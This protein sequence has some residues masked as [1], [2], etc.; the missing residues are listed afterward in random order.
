MPVDYNYSTYFVPPQKGLPLTGI[1]NLPAIW[2]GTYRDPEVLDFHVEDIVVEGERALPFQIA[3]D[4]KGH[5]DRLEF[6]MSRR[7]I[8]LVSPRNELAEVPRLTN[9]APL[10]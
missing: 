3:G 4:A 5:R 9:G 8:D 1:R 2:R 10:Q 7:R 6:T